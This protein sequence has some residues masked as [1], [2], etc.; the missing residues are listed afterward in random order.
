MAGNGTA[1]SQRLTTSQA[2]VLFLSAQQVER[3]EAVTPLIHGCFGIFGH[4]NAGGLGQ[5]LHQYRDRF[6]YY[7]G[8]NEQAMVHL[9]A[10]FARMRNRLGTYACASSIGPGAT[11]L[12]TGAAGATINRLPVLL[13]PADMAASRAPRPVLQQVEV[14][15]SAS[16]SVNDCLRPVSRYW[17]RIERPEQLLW[18]AP[19]AMRVLTDQ[20]ETGAVTLA[21]PTDVQAEAYDFPN[22]FFRPRVWHVPRPVPDPAAVARAVEVIRSARRPLIVCGGGAIYSEASEAVRALVDATGIPVAETHAGKGTLPYDHPSNL[23][24]LGVNG[25]PGSFE[26]AREADVVIGIGTRWTDV[27]S[28][29]QTAFANPEVRF[30]NLNIAAFD[31]HKF[32][33]EALVGDARA[34]LLLLAANL[35]GYQVASDHRERVARIAAEWDEEVDRYYDLGGAPLPSQGEVVGAVNAAAEPRDVVVCASGSMPNDLHK[36]WRSR[37][38]KSYQVEYGYSCMGYEIPGGIGAKLAAPDREVFVLVGDGAYMMMSSELATAVQEGIK[39]IVVLVQNHG[40]ASVGALSRRL[41]TD[42]FGTR[43][44]YRTETG[45]LDGGPLPVDLAANAASYGVNVIRVES[46]ADLREALAEARDAKV[47]T[48]IHVE[49]DPDVSV[50]RF[51]WWDVAIAEVAESASVREARAAYEVS[52]SESRRHL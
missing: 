16:I 50:P 9:A 38:P 10:G 12:V 31:A 23:G 20:A 49:T 51:H 37:D 14:P 11:N 52:R 35:A 33:G 22:E 8:R 47:T 34:T 7:L 30:V 3:D 36:L 32:S 40:F 18:S 19:E 6:P 26:I 42:G 5:A 17:D 21:L 41:G 4:G 46:V 28:V 27:T 48:L 43:Y 13:L 1:R 15:S 44:R 29:S 2:L 45:E 24:A 25:T 39:I